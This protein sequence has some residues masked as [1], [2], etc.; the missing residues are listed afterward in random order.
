M[1]RETPV[2]AGTASG[3]GMGDWGWVEDAELARVVVLSP[4]PDDAV[5]SCGQLLSRHPGATVVTVFCGY[6]ATYPDPPNA[7]AQLSGF[8]AGDDIVAARRAED[9]RA[10]ALLRATPV[11]LDGFAEADLQPTEPVATPE[12]VAAA[13]EA[14]LTGLCPTMVLL[15][16]GLANSEHVTVHDAALAVRARWPVAD[17]PSWIAYQDVAY[18]Q[19][20]GLLAWRVSK[21]FRSGIWPTPVAMPVDPDGRAKREAVAA[22]ASQ[23]RALEADWGLWRRLDAPTPE[24]YWRLAPPPA[25]WERLADL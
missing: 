14:V 9:E 16:L 13:L 20:P 24:Q 1:V 6:P 23:V 5:L 8:S 19:I 12:Q 4:H 2:V 10:L 22:Y 15:P 18:H 7:W 17:A 3:Q 25:G 21:L 11:H